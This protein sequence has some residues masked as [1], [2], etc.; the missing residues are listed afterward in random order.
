MNAPIAPS[1]WQAF[2][3][4]VSGVAGRFAMVGLALHCFLARP[5]RHSLGARSHESTLPPSLRSGPSQAGPA[6][7]GRQQVADWA[8]RAKTCFQTIDIVVKTSKKT[9]CQ[10]GNLRGASRL[11]ISPCLPHLW[12]SACRILHRAGWLVLPQAP[13]SVVF[14]GPRPVASIS[15]CRPGTRATELAAFG[16]ITPASRTIRANH[17][18]GPFVFARF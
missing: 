6:L 15:A 4:H 5:G 16:R 11:S 7:S 3:Q 10:R 9:T 14:R 1:I 2:A 18:G 8:G 13:S 12:P 17:P